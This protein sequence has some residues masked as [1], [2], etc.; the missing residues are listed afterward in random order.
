MKIKFNTKK[1][2]FNL[3]DR[4]KI[5][6][7]IVYANEDRYKHYNLNIINYTERDESTFII[8][9]LENKNKTFKGIGMKSQNRRGHWILP[10]E[11]LIK[12]KSE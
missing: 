2:I 7:P 3:G 6:W 8:D 1:L 10:K 5:N 4:V 11:I 12:I 9:D